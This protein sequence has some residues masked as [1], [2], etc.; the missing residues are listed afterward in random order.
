MRHRYV[1]G[2]HDR[3][4]ERSRPPEVAARRRSYPTFRAALVAARRLAERT[5]WATAVTW[6]EEPVRGTYFCTPL[7]WTLVLPPTETEVTGL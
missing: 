1:V 3:W 7:R 5:A 6:L 2:L 4:G